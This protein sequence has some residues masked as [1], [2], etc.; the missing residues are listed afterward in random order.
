MLAYHYVHYHD[1][2]VMIERRIQ[3]SLHWA[4]IRTHDWLQIR[5][6]KAIEAYLIE[7]GASSFLTWRPVKSGITGCLS[8]NL[9]T[10]KLLDAIT[11]LDDVQTGPK[12]LSAAS[13]AMIKE[14]FGRDDIAIR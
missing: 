3:R 2:P 1:L 13:F 10:S 9:V 8:R 6:D 14:V 5:R 7:A 12:A 4:R 11:H